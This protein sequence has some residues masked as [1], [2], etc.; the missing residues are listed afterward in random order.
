MS[1]EPFVFPE[2][3]NALRPAVVLGGVG[4]L[5]YMTII[6]YFGFS[7]KATDVG[8]EPVQPVP[9]SHRLHAGE[10]GIDCRYC[11]S[12]V[13]RTARATL[14]PT[15]TCMNCHRRIWP[16]SE[17]LLA[18]RRS[19]VSGMPIRWVRIH[20]LPQYAYFNH[21]VHLAKG[22]GC[23]ECHGRIDRMEQIRQVQ[24]L[25]MGFCLDCH[26]RPE[27]H[28]RPKELVTKMDFRPEGNPYD[29]GRK[30]RTKLKVQSKTDCQTCHR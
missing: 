28:L 8:Y 24:P 1:R 14:P 2:W 18:V 10:L 11:H 23:V 29:Y 5:V 20:K 25:S 6:V 30:M 13:E 17:K 4:G 19:Y 15:E 22:V 12:T 27:T 16:K 3:S 21:S 7:P 26:R 9:Y